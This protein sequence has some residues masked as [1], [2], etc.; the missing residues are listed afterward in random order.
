VYAIIRAGGKQQKVVPGDVIEIERLKGAKDTVEF[1]PLLV[2]ND[3]GEVSSDPSELAKARVTAQV[4]GEGK[5]EKIQVMKFRNKTG[6]R[7]KAGHRQLFTTIQIS[8][9]VVDGKPR[10]T[11]AARKSTGKKTAAKPRSEAAAPESKE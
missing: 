6:Y 4:L 1:T 11:G 3:E 5:G 9:I 7:R 10:S 2:V 8:E